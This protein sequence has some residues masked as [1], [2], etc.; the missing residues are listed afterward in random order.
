MWRIPR[1]VDKGAGGDPADLEGDFTVF[2]TDQPSSVVGTFVLPSPWRTNTDTVAKYVNSTAPTGPGDVKVG[3][4]KTGVV[5][6]V[7]AKGLGDGSVIDVFG[8]PPSASGGLTAVLTLRNAGDESERRFCT[9]FAENDGSTVVYK[10]LA[11]G[12]GRKI[13]AKNGV[14]APCP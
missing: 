4:L 1:G 3:V 11:G 5:A 9:R 2:Y 6:K 14:A 8:G 10:E 12:L 13:V 7:V